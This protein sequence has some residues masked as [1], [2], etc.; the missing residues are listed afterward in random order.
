MDFN[1]NHKKMKTKKA[2]LLATIF[3]AIIFLGAIA[4]SV[5]AQSKITIPSSASTGLSSKS[6]ATVLSNFLTWILGIL[7]IIAI[8]G[9]VVSGI[10]Y[11][12]ASGNEDLMETAKRNMMYCIIGVV[13]ALSAFVVL[14]AVNS[15]LG[16]SSTSF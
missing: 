6:V 16:G 9:F 7:G 3:L 15:L 4:S 1:F 2:N 13:V 12:T 8:I 5:G 11:I 10:Q 14:Q